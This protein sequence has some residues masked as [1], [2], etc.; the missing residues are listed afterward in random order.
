MIRS[1]TVADL[2]ALADLE[3]RLF[4]AG[5]WSRG[6]LAEAVDSADV[7]S[8]VASVGGTARAYAILRRAADEAELLR[9][10][11]SP[12]LRRQGLGR[13]L[14]TAGERWAVGSGAVRIFLEVRALDPRATAFYGALGYLPCGRRP[15]YYGP[16]EDALLMARPLS[17]APGSAP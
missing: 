5:P 8:A 6:S 13:A 11:V 3:R 10:G 12:D 2:H 7:F 17:V 14:L 4:P 16:G 15:H 9:I 1:A